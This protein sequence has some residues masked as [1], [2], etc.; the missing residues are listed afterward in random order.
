MDEKIT[1]NNLICY[2]EKVQFEAKIK[3][4]ESERDSE[5]RWAKQYFDQWEE[6]KARIKELEEGIKEYLDDPEF[7]SEILS[8]LIEKEKLNP[9][10]GAEDNWWEKEKP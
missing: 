1:C 5:T 6:A 3:E 4:L 10:P 9:T 8:K 2:A 7:D